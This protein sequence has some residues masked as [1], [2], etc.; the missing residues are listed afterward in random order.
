MKTTEEVLAINKN[1][2]EFY[3]T[4]KKNLATRI[5]SSVRGGALTK[6]RKEIGVQDQT[7]GL[8]KIW[9]GDLKNKK[10]LDLG[11]FS[12]N[13]LSVYI[14]ENAKEYIGIDLSDTAIAKLN[15]KLKHLPNATAKSVDF[16]S[17]AD[18]PDKNFDVVYA[19][20]VLH[21]FQNVDMIINRLNEKL[22]S[23]GC[24]IAYDPLQTSLPI[25]IIRTL[26]R[27]FQSDKDW[28][29]PFSIK[30]FYKFN[31]AFNIIERHG[32]LGKSKWFFLFNF[33]P[34]SNDKKVKIAKKWHHQDWETSSKND[35]KLFSCMHL[36]MYMQKRN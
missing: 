10:V 25:K 18:F 19:Y 4:K 12:G 3:N 32:I 13:N 11:C 1:Q 5:W 16:L 2:A 23:N 30:T 24:I 6:I 33:L 22:A 26:Y 20:G 14:A 27:P 28:E 21:H 17:D 15:D 7:Y 35:S 36:T 31:Q 34:I 8:H 29:W 9:L